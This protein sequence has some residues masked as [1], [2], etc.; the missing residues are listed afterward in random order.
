MARF[1]RLPLCCRLCCPAS[2]AQKKPSAIGG[3]RKAGAASGQ[4]TPDAPRWQPR[5]A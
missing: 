1:R 4:P 2:T 5:R 3:R